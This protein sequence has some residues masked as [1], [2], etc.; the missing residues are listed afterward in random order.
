M[1]PDKPGF[2]H[3]KSDGIV[4]VYFFSSLNMPSTL[5]Y[6]PYCIPVS[7]AAPTDWLGP[8][9]TAEEW[10]KAQARMARMEVAIGLAARQLDHEESEWN[11][12][13]NDAEDPAFMAAVMAGY[14]SDL[15]KALE[16]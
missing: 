12:G 16:P 14:A 8:V 13:A 6:G 11:N 5:G 1:V 15:R 3:H 4:D 7:D 9:P 2:W 10:A